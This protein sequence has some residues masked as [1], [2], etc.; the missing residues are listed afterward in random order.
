[1][2]TNKERKKTNPTSANNLE[3][4]QGKTQEQPTRR[5]GTFTNNQFDSVQTEEGEI[6]DL[7]TQ[8]KEDKLEVSMA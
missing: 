7:E 4:W 8:N 6:P 5:K 3:K 1:M 2:A